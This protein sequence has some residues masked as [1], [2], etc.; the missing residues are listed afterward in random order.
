MVPKANGQIGAWF[1]TMWSL[2]PPDASWILHQTV[3][4]GG[5]PDNTWIEGT[6]HQVGN[7]GGGDEI[8]GAWFVPAHGSNLV[9]RK[10]FPVMMLPHYFS[11]G[12]TS[13]Q[14]TTRT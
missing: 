4:N 5:L 2:Q 9:R 13:S 10:Y 8:H 6:H 3:P 11:A 7:P 1:Q 14:P 12:T